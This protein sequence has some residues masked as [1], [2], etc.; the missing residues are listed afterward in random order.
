MRVLLIRHSTAVDAYGAPT[1][2]TR[3]LT[4]EGRAR[5]REVAAVVAREVVPTRIFTSPLVRAVQTADLLAEG[6]GYSGAVEVHAPLA[7]EHGTTAQALAVLERAGE[8]DVVALVTH[9]PKVRVLAGHLAAVDR[10]PSF[11]TGAVCAID[12]G[13]DGKGHFAFW[14]EPDSGRVLRS[15]DA[16]VT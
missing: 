5:M 1:D 13:R 3:W 6:T 12:V 10:M 4:S 2:E 11:R 15:L 14:I 16:L 7:A 8:R 9:A